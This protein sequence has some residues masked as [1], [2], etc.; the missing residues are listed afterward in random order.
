[1][2]VPTPS[3][4]LRD[5]AGQPFVVENSACEVCCAT[6]RADRL[7]PSQLVSALW[8][9]GIAG[10]VA[11]RDTRRE[12]NEKVFR[13]GNERL[14]DAVEEHKKVPETAKVPFLCECA[15]EFCDGRVEL[16]RS[17]WKSIASNPNEFLMLPGHLRSEGEVVVGEFDGYEIVRKPD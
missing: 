4:A 3:G 6:A 5:E 16:E 14:S 11:S 2:C 12:Q 8:A 7:R 10:C 13:M 9:T 17:Q 15:D 1:V